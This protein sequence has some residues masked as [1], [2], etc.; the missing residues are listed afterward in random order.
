MREDA[1]GALI[2]SSDDEA[3]VE[4]VEEDAGPAE[5]P[6]AGGKRKAGEEGGEGAGGK[7]ARQAAAGDVIELD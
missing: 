5:A 6:R 7:L 2:L 4:V 3:E 1:D